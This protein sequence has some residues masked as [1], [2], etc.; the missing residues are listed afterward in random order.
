VAARSKSKGREKKKGT[1]KRAA[2][3]KPAPPAPAAK[4]IEAAATPGAPPAELKE[5]GPPPAD[6]PLKMQAWLHQVLVVSAF[7][8]ARD[9]KLS[10]R[11]RRKELRTIAASAAKLMPRARLLQA[12]QLILEDRA[13]LEKKAHERRG[14]KLE[15][16]PKPA[17]PATPEPHV[18]KPQS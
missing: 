5:L 15:A 13:Q 2:A 8:V 11:E 18:E 16:L 12:E 7:D 14:A 9:E 17:T 10:P 3:E 1:R 4:P 6:D